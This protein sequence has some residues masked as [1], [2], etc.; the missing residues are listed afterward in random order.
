[1]YVCIL[2]L[3]LS[4]S[5]LKPESLSVRTYVRVSVLLLY[6]RM[7]VPSSSAVVEKWIMT[8]KENNKRE[9]LRGKLFSEVSPL[10]KLSNFYLEL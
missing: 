10:V 5:L 7:V 3:R 4:T 9:L 8:A 1:M 2:Y 6:Q